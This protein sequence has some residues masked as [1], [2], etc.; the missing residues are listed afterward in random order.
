MPRTKQV[1]G[2]RRN[3]ECVDSLSEPT[4]RAEEI[5]EV[6][7]GVRYVHDGTALHCLRGGGLGHREEI[8]EDDGM[9]GEEP[10]V[11]PEGGVAA[12]ENDVAVVE[13]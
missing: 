10:A 12:E 8:A 7:W 13:P 11:D 2:R 4:Q 5:A 1:E 9:P 3:L 6:V